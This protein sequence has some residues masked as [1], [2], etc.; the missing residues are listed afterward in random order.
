MK[1]ILTSLLVASMV[2]CVSATVSDEVCDTVSLGTLPAATAGITLPPTTFNSPSE[3]YSS[4]VKKVS[5]ITS[6][7]IPSVNQL[8]LNNNGDLDFVSQVDVSINGA[9]GSAP[10]ANYQSNGSTPSN[11][12]DLDV[13]I[14]SATL[15]TYLQ[16]P[17]TLTFTIAGQPAQ[18]VPLTNTLCIGLSGS[19]SKSL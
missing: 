9:T 16:A 5:D 1:T 12:L 13:V 3:D 6:N 8:T 10:F 15:L 19:I 17:F 2:G 14:D 4:V 11:Q 18:S 7:I